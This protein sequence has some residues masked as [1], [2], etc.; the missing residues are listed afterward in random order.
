MDPESEKYYMEELEKQH[1]ADLEVK[2]ILQ[3]FEAR[4]E[5]MATIISDVSSGQAA[6]ATNIS[7]ITNRQEV[8]ATDVS[9]V[10]ARQAV[11]ATNIN[12]ITTRQET[13]TRD[14]DHLKDDVAAIKDTVNVISANTS[15]VKEIHPDLKPMIE[16]AEARI[17][18]EK[19]NLFYP[20]KGF[21]DAKVK[22]QKNR[23][24]V[25]KGN[26]GD[27]KTAIAVQ[28]LRWLSQEQGA[29]FLVKKEKH[30]SFDKDVVVV[31]EKHWSVEDVYRFNHDSIYVAVALLY[32]KVTPIGYIQ[33]CPRKSLSYLT[34]SETATNMIVISSDHYTEMC[35]RLL[36][37]FDCKESRYGT[38]IDSLDVWNDEEEY[39]DDI[40]IGSLDVWNDPVFLISFVGLLDDRKIDKLDVL[41]KACYSGAEECA[42]Y[43]LSEGVKPDKD[44]E[45]WS[46]FNRH[47]NDRNRQVCLLK[48][49]VVYFSDETKVAM[50]NEACYYNADECALYLLSEGVK[51]DKATELSLF[52]RHWN[53][54]NKECFLKKIFVYLNDETKVA[55]LNKACYSGAEECVIY[56]LSEGVKPDKETAWGSL[57]N[58]HRR[59]SN[60][61]L[62]LLKKIVVY[63]NDE[64]KVDVLNEV[65][66]HGAEEC[67]LYL[68]CEG[69]EPDKET[70]FS[71]VKGRR[72][73]VLRKL[74]EY[75]V[76]PTARDKYNNNNVLHM[77]CECKKEEMVTLLC[78]TYPHLV[79]YTDMLG[80]TPLHYV[81]GTGN[82]SIFQI[83]ERS[84]LNSLYRVEDQQHKCESVDGRVVH[85]NC[86]CAQYMAQ[87]V[88]MDGRMWI[89]GNREVCLYLCQSYPALT[90]AVDN[91]GK[92]VLHKSCEGGNREV[93]LYLCQSNPA[94]T[95]AV[96]KD[97]RHCLHYI[98]WSEFSDV[99]V[100]T[101]CETHVKQ[102][103]ESTGR[104]YDI[105][106]IFDN[107]GESV[108]DKAKEGAKKMARLWGTENNRLLDYLIDVFGKQK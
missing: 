24:V 100:F 49:I 50:L 10:S 70:P 67:A 20:N 2:A 28:L 80:R 65:C 43:L 42:L 63:L 18:K 71:V 19:E 27:G 81:V 1:K 12:N 59:D 5:V 79:H 3:D 61:Q 105:T 75:D 107:N 83:L 14:M 32:G 45:L 94:L 8:M 106:T 34:T 4:H 26:T 89:W 92:T 86:V 66:Y 69:V 104:K 91:D 52:Y 101:E 95:T 29:G 87:L 53:D 11:M 57:I 51:P 23:V 7:D 25:I 46:L 78:D 96:S 31:K 21:R 84:V 58:R 90:T 22:L 30:L 55:V 17:N 56:L 82:C 41:N 108:L 85:R 60:R 99:D 35:E 15:H 48:R 6:M 9:A 74:L 40:C 13:T 88:D 103:L 97:G 16:T 68:L 64:T 33:N 38:S 47:R 39:D 62:C 102:Y 54:S 98:A 36:R 72:V 73:K 76:T 93:C 77:A 37:E 44:T